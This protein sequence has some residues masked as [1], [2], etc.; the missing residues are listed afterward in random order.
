MDKRE[1]INVAKKY[2]VLLGS[3]DISVENA[4]LFGSYARGNFHKDSDIDLAIIMKDVENEYLT[5]L[6]LMQLTLDVD[7]RIEPHVI[8]KSDINSWNPLAS[9]VLKYGIKIN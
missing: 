7:L 3:K 8:D 2:L 1:A 6:E 5:Q 4:Y 9:E